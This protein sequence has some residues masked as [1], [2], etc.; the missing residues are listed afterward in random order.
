MEKQKT[1]VAYFSC[2]GYTRKVAKLLSEVVK[3]ELYE[4]T[5]AKPYTTS[6]LNWNN[7]NSRSSIEMK[8]KSSRPAISG[9]I[10]DFDS[11]NVVYLGFPIWWYIAPTIINTF[12]ESYDFSGKRVIPFCTSGSSGVG[13]TD[14]Y[15]QTSCSKQTKWHPTKR[16]PANVDKNSL[17]SWVN[18]LNL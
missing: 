4:I 5:P 1:L 17:A 18:S 3:G 15:L 11:F 2:S 14:M 13:Q 12:L 16:F 9:T 6:D 8:D 7:P 10:D